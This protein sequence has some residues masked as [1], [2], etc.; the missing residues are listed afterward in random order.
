MDTLNGFVWILKCCLIGSKILNKVDLYHEKLG[1]PIIDMAIF[2]IIKME[3]ILIQCLNYA[4][5]CTCHKHM[6]G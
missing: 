6:Q 3:I 5:I 1:E 2:S 4:L